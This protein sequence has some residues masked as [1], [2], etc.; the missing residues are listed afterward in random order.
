MP[1]IVAYLAANPYV[2]IT[3]LQFRI[4]VGGIYNI[5]AYNPGT[6]VATLDRPFADPGNAVAAYQLYQVYYVPPMKDFLCWLSVRNPTMFLNLG[7]NLTRSQLDAKDPQRTWYQFPSQVVTWGTDQ[8]G[9]GTANASASLGYPLFELWGQP[10]TPFTYQ[11]YGLRRGTKLVA[12]TDTLPPAVGEDLVL[13]KARELA[14]EWAEANKDMLP[15]GTGP[16][17]RFLMGKAAD[18]AKRLLI[19]YRRDD[20]GLIDNYFFVRG[21]DFNQAYGI[22]NTLA[23]VATPLSPG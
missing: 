9:A 8:R 7:L 14:Y 1:A 18:E 11:C 2:L 12:P 16:D 5:I 20:R 21:I 17:F 23:S 19:M 3:Q 6:G 15:R 4:A 10:V 22:Y 13:A